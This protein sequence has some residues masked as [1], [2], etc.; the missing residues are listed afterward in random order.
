MSA[1]LQR[2]IDMTRREIL[3]RHPY[4]IYYSSDGRWAT[5]LPDKDKKRRLVKRKDRSDLEDVIV[6]F[7][8]ETSLSFGDIY[9]KWRSYHDQMIGDSSALKYD[10]DEKRY[11]KNQRFFRMKIVSIRS[12]DVEVFIKRQID[13]LHLCQSAAKTLFHYLDNTFEF[14]MRHDYILKSPMRFMKAKDFYKYTYPSKRSEKPKVI[15]EETLEQLKARYDLDLSKHPDSIPVYAV[16][17]S[18]LTGMRVGEIAALRWDS[19]FDD[20]ILVDK[21]QKYNP[22]LGQYYISKTKNSKIRKF[23]VTQE[24]KLLLDQVK[25]IED[26]FEYT[27]DYI[28]SDA[29]G[30]INF[31]K[32]SSCIKNKCRQIGVDTLG[33]HAY[34]RTVNSKMALNGVPT[35]IR[36]AL[37]GHSSEVNER[38]YTFDVSTMDEKLEI[39][40]KVNAQMK[41]L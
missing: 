13:E 2:Q 15:P 3:K 9:R 36:A 25:A 11:F 14:A 10:S 23:P 34:R 35:N 5:Y 1:Y 40:A 18:S 17:L 31:R 30:P 32:I 19:V 8:D 16:I 29:S 26:Q 39:M 33:I 21:S 12:D 24:I 4:Q 27:T 41:S 22:K 38:Y 20:Y 28:F 6:Q 7:Y 37:L